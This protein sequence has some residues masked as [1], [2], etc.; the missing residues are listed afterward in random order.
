M[1]SAAS[2]LSILPL[3]LGFWWAF[4]DPKKQTWHDEMLRTYVL[5]DTPELSRRRGTSSTTAVVVFWVL[6]GTVLALVAVAALL[7]LLVSFT[8]P[9]VGPGRRATEKTN[10][11]A[12]FDLLMTDARITRLET[13]ANAIQ[14]WKGLPRNPDG[15]PVREGDRTVDL[16]RYLRVP[17]TVYFYCWDFTGKV[18]RQAEGP[19]P[20]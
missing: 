18:T 12:A 1:R 17:T 15:S 4:W 5:T 3:G 19:V 16:S 9:D 14:S 2:F 20:C 7:P 10:V 8:P 13:N 11:Q 6:L